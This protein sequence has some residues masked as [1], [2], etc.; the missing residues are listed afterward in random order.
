M[1][2]QA[3]QKEGSNHGI[4]ES[5]LIGGKGLALGMVINDD[6]MQRSNSVILEIP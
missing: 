1:S 2:F 3:T 5:N 6:P 4:T